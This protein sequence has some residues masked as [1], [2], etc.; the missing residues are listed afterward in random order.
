[1]RKNT[2]RAFSASFVL[3]LLFASAPAQQS[4]QPIVRSVQEDPVAGAEQEPMIFRKGTSTLA[5]V[6]GILEI[7]VTQLSG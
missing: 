5:E 3:F 1:M 2:L 6:N 4:S 7:I